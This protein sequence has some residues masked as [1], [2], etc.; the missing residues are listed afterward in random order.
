MPC[1]GHP[2]DHYTSWQQ[3]AQACT[4]A[5]PPHSVVMGFSLG[6][7]P[8]LL[9]VI[10]FG[11]H[12]TPHHPAVVGF[13]IASG[14]RRLAQWFAH[15]NAHQITCRIA[16]F[17]YLLMSIPS[18][19]G[20]QYLLTAIPTVCAPQCSSNRASDRS[21]L[22]LIDCYLNGLHAAILVE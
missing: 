8:Y 15:R 9:A 18:G 7:T 2:H 21:S 1:R 4:P 10:T 20:L 17:F 12:P 14:C 16:H 19:C 5:S 6:P 3:Q 13:L 22:P 11:L